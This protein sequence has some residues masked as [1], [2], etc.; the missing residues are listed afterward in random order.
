ML[1]LVSLTS[2]HLSFSSGNTPLLKTIALAEEDEDEE[3]EY[4]AE[5]EA[6]KTKKKT[7]STKTV[8][9]IKKVIE[10]KPVQ[11]TVMVTEDAYQKDTDGDLLVDAID[12]DPLVHQAEYFTDTDNDGVPNAID[13]FHDEDDFSYYEFETDDDNNGILDSYEG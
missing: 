12:P 10:Y 1:L 13:Q 11:Q 6:P 4:E 3:E 9:V 7:S 5:E 2:F 8:E